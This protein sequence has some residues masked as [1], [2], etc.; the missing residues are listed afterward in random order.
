[1]PASPFVARPTRSGPSARRV[2]RL[3]THLRPA[4]PIVSEPSTPAEATGC[5]PLTSSPRWSNRQAAA[6]KPPILAQDRRAGCSSSGSGCAPVVACR[7]ESRTGGL[8]ASNDR[9]SKK[10]AW[11]NSGL[12]ANHPCPTPRA[13][14]GRPADLP[15]LVVSVQTTQLQDLANLFDQLSERARTPPPLLHHCPAR[16]SPRESLAKILTSPLTSLRHLLSTVPTIS[17][18]PVTTK[19]PASTRTRKT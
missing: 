10:L 18:P 9:F 2:G 15:V 13:A 11:L 4:Y 5:L 8:F 19:T 7:S 3:R 12:G 1:M 17:N 14:L 16:R 6:L